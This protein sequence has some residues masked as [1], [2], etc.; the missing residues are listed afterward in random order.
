[1]QAIEAHGDVDALSTGHAEQAPF[2]ITVVDTNQHGQRVL[3][4]ALLIYKQGVISQ[5]DRPTLPQSL[6]FLL[7]AYFVLNLEFPLAYDSF[8]RLLEK[9]IHGALSEN[10]AKKRAK[11]EYFNYMKTKFGVS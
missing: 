10:T 1:M 7:G 9:Q 4:K 2:L 3:T 8:L 6:I 11:K 5:L